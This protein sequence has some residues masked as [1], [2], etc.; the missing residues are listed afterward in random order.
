MAD[1]ERQ[2][3]PQLA[4]LLDELREELV[5]ER[6]TGRWPTRVAVSRHSYEALLATKDRELRRGHRLRVLGLDVVAA[7]ALVGYEVVLT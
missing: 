5:R 2:D 6:E 1:D 4:Q 3:G 7:E